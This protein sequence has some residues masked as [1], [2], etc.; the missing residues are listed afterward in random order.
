MGRMVDDD[1][2]L[3]A[4]LRRYDGDGFERLVERHGDR[5]YRLALRITRVEEDAEEAV[6]DALRAAVDAIDTF[7]GQ[8]T[9]ESWLAQRVAR[10]A[11]QSVRRRGSDSTQIALADVVPSLDRD[12]RHFE[13][14][15]DWSSRI[16]SRVIQTELAGILA[17]ATDALPADY[18]T[19]LILHDAEGMSKSDIAAILDVDERTVASRVHR[20]RLFVRKRLSEYF[21]SVQVIQAP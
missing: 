11:Y 21:A 8:S 15:D 16:D 19:A 1:A 5:N 13:P 9:F 10:A 3:V 4:A 2:A 6:A 18:R 20:A 7:T 14:M 17:E 12:G